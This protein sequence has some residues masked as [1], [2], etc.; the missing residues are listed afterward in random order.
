MF[1]LSATRPLQAYNGI[2]ATT[3]A[4]RGTATEDKPVTEYVEEQQVTSANRPALDY[5]NY[6]PRTFWSDLAP[7]SRTSYTGWSEA[8]NMCKHMVQMICFPNVLL[9]VLCN[10]WFL[11]VSAAG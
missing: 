10:S 11:G 8:W 1:P 3:P 2:T 9:I 6:K 5:V 7:F 4:A